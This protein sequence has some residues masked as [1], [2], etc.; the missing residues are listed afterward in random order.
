MSPDQMEMWVSMIGWLLSSV[1]LVLLLR[2]R[3]G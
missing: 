3:Y 1:G 2:R